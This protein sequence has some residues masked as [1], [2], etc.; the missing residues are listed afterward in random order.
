[1]ISWASIDLNNWFLMIL[2]L[3]VDPS[4]AAVL[5]FVV[6]EKVEVG[7]MGERGMITDGGNMDLGMD[8]RQRRRNALL[9]WSIIRLDAI[10]IMLISCRY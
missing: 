8:P 10:I 2:D 9:E 5:V 1:M 6:V 4:S 3:V 7:W